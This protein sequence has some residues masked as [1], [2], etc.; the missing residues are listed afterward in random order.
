MPIQPEKP[1]GGGPKT[2]TTTTT[3]TPK[4]PKKQ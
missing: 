4:K 3:S 1:I 2:A